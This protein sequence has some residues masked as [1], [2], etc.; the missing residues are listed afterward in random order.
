MT[1]QR[2]NIEYVAPTYEQYLATFEKGLARLIAEVSAMTSESEL[3]TMQRR[4]FGYLFSIAKGQLMWNK[5]KIVAA[6]DPLNTGVVRCLDCCPVAY[7]RV[8][9][10]A[11]KFGPEEVI[12]DIQI[13]TRSEAAEW[14]IDHGHKVGYTPGQI[15]IA[16]AE[17][18]V[19]RRRAA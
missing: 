14:I 4:E 13:M 6:F 19:L 10:F 16:R 2:H 1:R 15:E 11:E 7:R 8:G 3:T 12:T 9:A 17:K 5:D 18:K